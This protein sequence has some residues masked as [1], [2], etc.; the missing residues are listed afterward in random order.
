MKEPADPGKPG[1]ARHIFGPRPLGALV[2]GL[3]RPA[4]RKR[5]PAA[6]Q[7][8]ADWAAIVGPKLAQ[9]TVPRKLA[10]GTLTLA[11]SGPV[12][13]ELQHLAEA[14]IARIN[15]HVGGQT[16]QRLRFV[17]ASPTTA[18]IAT[19]AKPDTQ[20]AARAEQAVRD[21]PAGELRDALLALGTAVLTRR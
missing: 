6:A 17:Q 19:P 13:L 14:L 15:G 4:F 1:A 2:P 10:A 21:L 9:E 20:A 5:A 3:V 7:V 8:M 11:C 16:V 18:A 12:A